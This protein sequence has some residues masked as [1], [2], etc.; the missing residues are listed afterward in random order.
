VVRERLGWST[1]EAWIADLVVAVGA[2]RLG[3]GKA[4][5]R[6]CTELA[7]SRGCRLMR[8][9]CGSQRHEARAFYDRLGFRLFGVD[10]R[11]PFE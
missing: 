3:V 8:L 11:L 9:E 2:R 4:L 6:G 1:P 5:V 7:R 10:L